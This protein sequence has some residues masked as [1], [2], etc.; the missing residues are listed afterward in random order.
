[1]PA[2]TFWEVGFGRGDEII[3]FIFMGGGGGGRRGWGPSKC[4]RKRGRATTMRT[5]S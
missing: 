3:M 4:K 2:V 5:F 1:M